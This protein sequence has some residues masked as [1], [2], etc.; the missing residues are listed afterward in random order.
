MYGIYGNI[1]HQYT[2]NVSIYTIHGS[3]GYG[4]VMVSRGFWWFV[5]FCLNIGYPL[6]IQSKPRGLS[7]CFPLNIAI[8]WCFCGIPHFQKHPKSPN[9]RI[10]LLLHQYPQ[11]HPHSLCLNHPQIH[12]LNGSYISHP[13]F[14]HIWNLK[15]TIINR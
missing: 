12:G 13:S 9:Y 5:M 7:S 10:N 1:Y 3:Y 8:S 11:N 6:I 15:I 2:P 14:Y 4:L